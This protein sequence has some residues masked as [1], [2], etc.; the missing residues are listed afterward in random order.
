MSYDKLMRDEIDKIEPPSLREKILARRAG[1][2]AV[3]PVGEHAYPSN[4]KP[5]VHWAIDEAWEILDKLPVGLLPNDYRFWLAGVIAG[6][7]M[8][9]RL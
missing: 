9:R 5:G 2:E 7:L 6:T 3:P 4:F 8:R 1:P